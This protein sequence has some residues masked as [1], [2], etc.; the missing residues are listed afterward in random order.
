MESWEIE[1]F[2]EELSEGLLRIE[3]LYA[4]PVWRVW[5]KSVS[6]VRMDIWYGEL[7]DGELGDG[8]LGDGELG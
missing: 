1:S 6:S 2:D 5:M 8:E 4:E 7:G 3:N